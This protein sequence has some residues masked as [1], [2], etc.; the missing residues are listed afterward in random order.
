[1]LAKIIYFDCALLI[2]D[3]VTIYDLRKFLL[4][5]L[6]GKKS[7]N[8]ANQVYATQSLRDKIMLSF[9]KA[10][11]KKYIKEFTAFHRMYKVVVYTLIPQYAILIVSNVLLGMK[12]MYVLC[13][14]AVV[15]L[16]ICFLV[17]INV[18]SNRVSIYRKK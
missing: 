18:D 16:I 9:I 15:K 3:F 2:L 1:M 11:L 6:R 8:N 4:D 10:H 13:F 17:R 7:R 5:F 12:S 14:F